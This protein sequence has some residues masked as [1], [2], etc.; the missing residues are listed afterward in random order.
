MY[1]QHSFDWILLIIIWVH[2]IHYVCVMYHRAVPTGN[3]CIR[4]A[5]KI[6]TLNNNISICS[7]ISAYSYHW[8]DITLV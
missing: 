7:N 1:D 2:I 4:M 3:N 5:I 6:S 8:E